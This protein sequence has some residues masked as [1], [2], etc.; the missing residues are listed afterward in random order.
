MEPRIVEFS[1]CRVIGMQYV[2]K[3]EQ[4]EIPAMWGGETGFVARMGEVQSPPEAKY[5]GS[6]RHAVFGLCR[7]LPG[8]DD[9]VFEYVAAAPATADAPIPEGMIETSLPTGPYLAFPV[10]GLENLGSAWGQTHEWL[11]AHPEW[12]SYCTGP[13]DC[14]CANHPSFE[15]YPPDFGADGLFFLYVPVRPSA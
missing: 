8:R 4:G 5:E 15:L 11:V 7:C 6:D 9:G 13:E 2:G 14:D 12:K 3:N 10:Q 1:G